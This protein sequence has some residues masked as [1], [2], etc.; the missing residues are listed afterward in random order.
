MIDLKHIHCASSL[1]DCCGVVFEYEG[2]FFRA[3]LPRGLKIFEL[4]CKD[5]WM[6][7]LAE[8]G[9]A[10]MK[11]TDLQLPGYQG[12]I[13]LERLQPIIPPSMWT[14]NMLAEAGLAVCRLSKELLRGGLIIW[15]LKGM[16]NMTFSAE[17]GPLLMD[18]GAIHTIDEVENRILT[19]S[20]Q[21]LFD[22]IVSSF[23]APL[24]LAHGPFRRLQKVQRFLEYRRAGEEGFAMASSLLRKMTMGWRFVPGLVKARDMI[25][26]H[27]YSEFYDLV[28]KKMQIWINGNLSKTT[29]DLRK[30]NSLYSDPQVLI[31]LM[32]IVEKAK[33][34][35]GA[36]VVCDLNPAG[37]FG[38]TLAERSEEIVYVVTKDSNQAEEYFHLRRKG[39]K[40]ILPVCCDIWD[41]SLKNGRILKNSCDIVC[42]IPDVI[43]VCIAEK[44]PLDILGELLSLITKNIAIVGVDPAGQRGEFPGF[45]TP[46]S[47]DADPIKFVSD[48]VGKYFR[49]CE[50]AQIPEGRNLSLMIF[51]K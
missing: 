24:W 29:I 19:T 15:D 45:V 12:I 48:I 20:V 33:G 21:S 44:V 39:Y 16:T 47:T 42:L 22:Q 10:R 32:K 23:Y 9:L 3:L 31:P 41:R 27:Q 4:L 35:I 43:E 5:G 7:N 8:K 6:E 50:M 18:I 26:A 1:H 17:R 46:A 30:N 36:K 37:N 38:L 49:S 14:N 13:E 2:K 25:Y 11:L 51:R 40:T 28:Y 34:G